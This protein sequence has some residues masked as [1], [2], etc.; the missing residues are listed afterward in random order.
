MDT[1]FV[2]WNPNGGNP[3]YR[4]A[5][6]ELARAEAERLCRAHPGETFFV[7]EALGQVATAPVVAPQW[8]AAIN[9]PF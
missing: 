5:T 2:V 8:T 4:H 3:T 7:L 1:F 6:A 9:M